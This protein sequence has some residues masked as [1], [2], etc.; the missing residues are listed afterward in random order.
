MLSDD[1][2]LNILKW[3]NLLCV[4][5]QFKNATYHEGVL[6]LLKSFFFSVVLLLKRYPSLYQLW[7][8]GKEGLAGG[9]VCPLSMSEVV[10]EYMGCKCRPAS[11]VSDCARST[12]PQA[13]SRLHWA[14]HSLSI[15]GALRSLIWVTFRRRVPCWMSANKALRP[16]RSVFLKLGASVLTCKG[17]GI[18]QSSDKAFA[19]KQNAPISCTS[20][21]QA[22]CRFCL[23][24]K[25]KHTHT[26][27]YSL[28]SC[29]HPSPWDIK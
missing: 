25:A 24:P 28:R 22:F 2:Q 1:T 16:F 15:C 17:I 12:P 5:Y 26:I 10:W 9:M 8:F 6:V 7:T 27:M 14:A 21:L 11:S 18:W 20:L 3:W 23:I 4:F 13:P 19:G 29:P